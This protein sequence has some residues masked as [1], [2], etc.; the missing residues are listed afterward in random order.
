MQKLKIQKN[1]PGF[2]CEILPKELELV[3]TGKIRPDVDAPDYHIQ[4][5]HAVFPEV[6]ILHPKIE[7]NSEIHMYRDET[8]CLYFPE[9]Y[10]WDDI[11][12]IHDTVIPW[13]AE[14]LVF[15]ELY[16][17]TGKWKGRK[18]PH[19]LPEKKESTLP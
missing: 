1:Y 17:L 12:S 19:K 15:Y 6:R 13:T 16:L 4:I 18:A 8:L 9:D 5:R 14:W 7:P 3:C 10:E 2:K 11:S